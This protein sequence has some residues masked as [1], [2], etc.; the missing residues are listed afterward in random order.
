[1]KRP[2]T[3][4]L[5]RALSKL[6]FAS[7]SEAVALIRE[8]RVRVDG[9]IARAPEQAVVPERITVA[10]DGRPVE[11]AARVTILLHKPR[12][13]VTTRRDPEGRPTVLDL[14]ASAPA[15]VFPVGRLDLAT[16]GLLLLTN[17]SKFADWITDPANQ[18]PRTNV[19]TVRG[20]LD[21]R[22][23]ARIE[24]SPIAA[25]GTRRPAIEVRK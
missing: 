21:E 10:I 9:R 1:M 15:R 25:G 22:A 14:V 24:Q 5:A 17:D 2:G 8:G 19:V 20:D 12:G 16:T 3:V 13:V 6:G 7:R 23:C 11:R 4:P 18:V